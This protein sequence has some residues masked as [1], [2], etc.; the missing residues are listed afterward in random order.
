MIDE[1]RGFTSILAKRD[2]PPEGL[3]AL[4]DDA[5]GKRIELRAHGTVF[6]SLVVSGSLACS[7]RL[8]K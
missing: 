4:I 8:N 7:T 6:L 2:I 1:R 3:V 5:Y